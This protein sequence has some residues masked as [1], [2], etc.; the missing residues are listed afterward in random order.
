MS[1]ADHTVT[2]ESRWPKIIGGFSIAYALLG[3][4]CSCFQGGWLVALPL[5]KDKLPGPMQMMADIPAFMRISGIAMALLGLGLAILMIVGAARVMRRIRSGVG[6]LTTWAVLRM[7]LLV[8]GIAVALLNAPVQIQMQRAGEEMGNEQLREAG[9]DDLVE[10][11]DDATLWRKAMIQTGIFS[12]VVA[13][14]PMFLGFYLTRRKL[15]Q[16][17]SRWP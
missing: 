16:E 10:S 2:E 17:V 8:L 11:S 5:M 14:Y 9:R 6:L 12:G 1:E 13:I 7:V 4:T 15:R 3:L